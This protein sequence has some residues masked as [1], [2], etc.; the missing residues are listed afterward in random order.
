MY[1]YYDTFNNNWCVKIAFDFALPSIIHIHYFYNS[2]EKILFSTRIACFCTQTACIS[3]VI[4]VFAAWLRHICQ[5]AVN[6]REKSFI[7]Q[8]IN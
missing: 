6:E 3:C 1:Y 2:C 8:V 7:S 5:M 4:L